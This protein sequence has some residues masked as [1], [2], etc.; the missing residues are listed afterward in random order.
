MRARPV[1]AAL[2]SLALLAVGIGA[3]R[4][5]RSSSPAPLVSNT[6]APTQAARLD[7]VAARLT[8]ADHP[9]EGRRILADLRTWLDSLPREV[10]SREVLAFLRQ[11][12]DATTKLDV[13]VKTGGVIED[14]SSLRVFML[15][16]LGQ[17]DRPAASVMSREIL[18]APTSPDE[19]AV[20]LRNVAWADPSPESLGYL[21]A[22]IR[23]MISNP[24]WRQN[25]SAGFLEAFD[26][27]VY[28]QG[29]D[30]VPLLAELVCS[31]E[32][33]A[34]AHAAF[35]TLDR[36]TIAD[37]VATLPPLAA[38]PDLLEGREPT[39]A[40]LFARADLRD[41]RQKAVVESYLLDPRR[42]PQEL[43]TFAGLFPNANY[44]ISENL[45]TKSLTPSQPELAARDRAALGAVETWLT[46]AR[47]AKLLP[48]LVSLR[49]RLRGFVASDARQ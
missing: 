18:S 22:K 38:Q 6:L 36:L 7:D 2:A 3:W 25:P 45:L 37:P 33:R 21:R 35:L 46:D 15:D 39:R 43:Q 12:R 4:N 34:A 29:F 26:V 20:S 47:F 49:A 32:N 9:E 48:H 30:L 10:A 13:A 40:G 8:A 42:S 1:A 17:I 14:A 19:W 23:E 28:A 41:P 11:K 27:I 16:Y 44:L 31:R 5:A 24:A